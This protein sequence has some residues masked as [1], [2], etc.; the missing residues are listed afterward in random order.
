MYGFLLSCNIAAITV[1]IKNPDFTSLPVQDFDWLDTVYVKVQEP[2]AKD[3]PEAL[4]IPVASVSY[5]NA[6]S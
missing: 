4:E 5:F 2:I 3:T 6:N 1:C